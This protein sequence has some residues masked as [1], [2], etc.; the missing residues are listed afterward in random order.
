MSAG[1]FARELKQKSELVR[2]DINYA[3]VIATRVYDR[4]FKNTCQI[5]RTHV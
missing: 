4:S 3:K 5:G 2:S 1:D